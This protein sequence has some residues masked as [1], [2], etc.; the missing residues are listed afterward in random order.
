MVYPIRTRVPAT[1]GRIPTSTVS[2]PMSFAILP[3]SAGVFGV[4]I[5][6]LICIAVSLA[7]PA[8]SDQVRRFVRNLRRPGHLG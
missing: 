8:P 6:F 1:S 5:G 4:P 3:V 2:A 7:T